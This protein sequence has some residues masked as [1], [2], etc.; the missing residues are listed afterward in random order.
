MHLSTARYR[1]LGLENDPTGEIQRFTVAYFFKI[2]FLPKSP[3][4]RLSDTAHQANRGCSSAAAAAAAAVSL[5]AAAAQLTGKKWVGAPGSQH[6]VALCADV[7]HNL[8]ARWFHQDLS[9][10]LRLRHYLKSG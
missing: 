8:P 1:A 3:E 2:S 6:G 9:L 4:L 7:I 5:C 10:G